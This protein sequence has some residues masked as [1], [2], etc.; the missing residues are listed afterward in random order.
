[1]DFFELAKTRE[2]CRS[3]SD[4]MVEPE[5]LTKCVETARLGHLSQADME[6]DF[7]PGT[8]VAD[9]VTQVSYRVL[10]GGAKEML[11]V[12]DRT[13]RVVDMSDRALDEALDEA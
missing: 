10:P 1:M 3:F 6:V 12:A 5:L 7:P 11:P 8:V 2:S 4:K 13:G 9:F